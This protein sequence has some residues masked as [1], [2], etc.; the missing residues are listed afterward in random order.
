MELEAIIQAVEEEAMR[1][2]AMATLPDIGRDHARQ[3]ALLREGAALLRALG[4]KDGQVDRRFSQCGEIRQGC[5]NG[6][7]F[8]RVSVEN[9]ACTG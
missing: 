3:S 1:H 2:R 4:D 8:R 6:Q 5:Q 9:A 7:I